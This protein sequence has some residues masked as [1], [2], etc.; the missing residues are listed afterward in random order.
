MLDNQIAIKAVHHSV[1][2]ILCFELLTTL[3]RNFKVNMIALMGDG[4]S[5]LTNKGRPFPRLS[6]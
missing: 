1:K 6:H 2:Q 5:L 3:R 4:Y